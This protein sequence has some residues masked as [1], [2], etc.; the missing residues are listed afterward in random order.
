VNFTV[1]VNPSNTARTGTLTIADL[2]FT[3]NQIANPAGCLFVL[4]PT[5]QNFTSAAGTG[6]ISVGTGEDCEWT[7]VS[8]DSFITVTSGASGTGPGTV[9]YSVAANPDGIARTGTI[10]IAGLTFTVNQDPVPCVFGLNP[11]SQN[12]SQVGGSGT[13][14]VSAPNGC[15]WTAV[16]NAAFITVTSGATGSGP[17]TVGFTVAANPGVS[18]RTGTITIGGITFTVNQQGNCNFTIS[19]TTKNFLVS[20][21]TG[22]VTVT[23]DDQNCARTATTNVSWITITQGASGTG[24]GT[25]KYTVAPNTT[26]SK[27]TGQVNI[28]GRIHTVTQAG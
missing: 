11:T 7:A 4:M 21:G 28:E 3:V 15:D 5:S 8:N 23:A 27:R 14:T 24:S 25:V 19:P 13:V 26:R 22:T 9:N 2:T 10:T 1:A 17:G 18:S 12:F 16:S 6:S 20:G